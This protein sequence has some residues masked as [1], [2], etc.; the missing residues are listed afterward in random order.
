MLNS[1]RRMLAIALL[2]GCASALGSGQ[3]SASDDQD[4]ERA[5]RALEA[6]EVMP[7]RGLIEVVEREHP[8]EIVE[9]ELEREDGRWIYEIKQL[10][11]DGSM[12]KLKVDASDGRV[13]SIRG[14]D[15]DGRRTEERVR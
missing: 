15:A 8:G 10:R 7:L 5:R 6:G 14:R 4:H 11:R 13:L 9:I 12:S 2:I 1:P 3:S